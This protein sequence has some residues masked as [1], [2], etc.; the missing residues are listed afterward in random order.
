MKIKQTD[1]LNALSSMLQAKGFTL[2]EFLVVLSIIVF[3]VP[4]LFGLMY[5]LLRQQSRIIALQEVKR[6]GDLVFNHMK[7]TIKNSATATYNNTLASPIAICTSAPTSASGSLMYFLSST[8]VNSY[9]GYSMSGT[10]IVYEKTG[11]SSTPLTNSTVT[12]SNLVLACSRDS[13]Y[14]PPLVSVSYTVTQPSTSVSLNYKTSIKLKS[15]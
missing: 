13:D 15:H 4:S 8:G 11:S 7:T 6:Q 2:I 9:F 3:I 14:S 10:G 5:S 1:K 12:I